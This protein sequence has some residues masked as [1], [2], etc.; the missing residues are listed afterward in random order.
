MDA[1]TKDRPLNV[2]ILKDT[3]SARTGATKLMLQVA[4]AFLSHGDKV[5]LVFFSDDGSRHLIENRLARFDVMIQQSTLSKYVSILTQVPIIKL[6]MKDAFSIK[7]GI[8]VLDQFAFVRKLRRRKTC[9]DLII[10]MSI[11]SGFMLPLL[12]DS[13][14]VRTILYFH[15][16]PTFSG[17]PF[18]L[19]IL[20]RL[21]MHILRPHVALNVSIT[22]AMARSIAN[23]STLRTAVV[24]DAFY[25]RPVIREKQPFVLLDT[26]W[27]VVRNPF[28]VADIADV[29]KNIRFV[30]CGSFGSVALKQKFLN[31]LKERHLEQVVE[32]KENLEEDELEALYSRARCYV[33]W[34]GKSTD[35]TGP[36]FGLVQAV[37]NGCVPIISDNLGSARYVRQFVGDDFVVKNDAAEFASA[38][39]R[40][41]SDGKFFD[42]ALKRVIEWRDGYTAR[43]YR[44]LLLSYL[45]KDFTPNPSSDGASA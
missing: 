6:F 34:S 18:P 1:E 37:S 27:T 29:L 40:V 13:Y 10:V 42:D 38:I 15:E 9:Y 4:D 12:D 5:T 11:W 3:L 39:K 19:R 30:M 2:L 17:L 32:M 21:H 22:H 43:D 8:N 45:G 20:L 41:F 26:R 33:R 28:M 7:D 36:S 35:E 25:E 44:K 23:E 24:P 31:E 16:P 14:K